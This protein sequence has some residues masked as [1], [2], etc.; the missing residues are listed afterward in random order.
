[1]S[2]GPFQ[3][4]K[5]I[6]GFFHAEPPSSAEVMDEVLTEFP[7]QVRPSSDFIMSQMPECDKVSAKN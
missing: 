3:N 6:N 1:M 7:K 5:Y 2:R 4:I